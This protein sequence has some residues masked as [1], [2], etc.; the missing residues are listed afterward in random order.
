MSSY[1]EAQPRKDYYAVVSL[2]TIPDV[3]GEGIK[4]AELSNGEFIRLDD[5]QYEQAKKG[6]YQHYP[7][8]D[9]A[10]EWIQP[11]CVKGGFSLYGRKLFFD[12]KNVGSIIGGGDKH[13]KRMDY[14]YVGTHYVRL[15]KDYATTPQG[16]ILTSFSHKN[17]PETFAEWQ[18]TLNEINANIST[19]HTEELVLG[20]YT[21]DDL[22]SSI[23]GPHGTES[24]EDAVAWNHGLAEN[25][26]SE[27]SYSL[28]AESNRGVRPMSKNNMWT[29]VMVLG[30]AA[31]V[32]FY[33]DRIVSMFR[34]GNGE[35]ESNAESMQNEAN[36]GFMENWQGGN[37]GTP[38]DNP[39]LEATTLQG[40]VQDEPQIRYDYQPN[41]G[42][43]HIFHDSKT[44]QTGF[45]EY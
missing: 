3:S 26:E 4:V 30:G 12:C 38:A 2:Y 5:E 39:R 37:S 8:E 34:G 20:K 11:T 40:P 28:S 31:L 27:P 22:V 14:P 29:N 1:P 10:V 24:Y 35:E 17:S 19:Y 36:Q 7:N 9:M 44:R 6:I 43:S 41:Q 33:F 42:P 16:K 21:L 25:F 18:D 32:G 15:L 13:E 23:V 45:F